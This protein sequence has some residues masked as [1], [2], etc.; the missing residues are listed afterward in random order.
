MHGSGDLV[1]VVV[2]ARRLRQE[3]PGHIRNYL[4]GDHFWSPSYFAAS[5]GA[6]RSLSSRSTSKT[7]NVPAEANRADPCAAR[8]R[9][10]LRSASSRARTT[11]LEKS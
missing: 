4:W 9:A 10:V 1:G 11:P 8:V 3:F 7:R 2:S 6:P 5:C